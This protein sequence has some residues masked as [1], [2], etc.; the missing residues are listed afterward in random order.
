MSGAGH[1]Q[2]PAMLP[3]HALVARDHASC[4]RYLAVHDFKGQRR[5]LGGM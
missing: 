5:G 2:E 3:G 1:R 4:A